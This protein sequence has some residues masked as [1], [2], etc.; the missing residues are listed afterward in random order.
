MPSILLEVCIA[1]VEDAV[2]ACSGGAER[3][4]LNI[5]IEVGGLTPS[6]GLLEEVKEAVGL[7]VVAMV[8][9]R[10]AGFRFSQMERRVMMRDAELLLSAGADGIVCGALS[11]DGALDF[12]FWQ[13]LRRLTEGRQLVF[14]RAMDVMPDQSTVLRQLIES[15][16]TRVLT[17]GGRQTAWAGRRQIAR[18]RELANGQIEILPGA[19]VGPSN[20][21]SLVQATGCDQ[22]H[23][24]FRELKH[25]PAGDVAD[26]KYPATSEQLVAATRA[27]LDTRG[28]N[29]MGHQ[30]VQHD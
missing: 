1:S 22:L 17:S 26:A 29:E 20:A 21:V 3:L 24:T 10:A 7:P 14:H 11:E 12:C 16:T 15:D 25:D 13:Q 2:A 5:G 6:V 4:E 30:A 8:R 18:L 9:P 28:K 19:G 27:A 23:G